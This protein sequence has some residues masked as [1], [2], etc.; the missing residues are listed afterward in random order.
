MTITVEYNEDTRV[1]SIYMAKFLC[2]QIFY[3]SQSSFNNTPTTFWHRFAGKS[4]PD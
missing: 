1:V 3:V 2:A 4:S